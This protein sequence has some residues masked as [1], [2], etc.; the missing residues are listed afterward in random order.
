MTT[1][2]TN[3]GGA[4]I[5]A[6]CSSTF[7]SLKMEGVDYLGSLTATKT[8]D[9]CEAYAALYTG[10]AVGEKGKLCGDMVAARA[11]AQNQP[12]TAM[13]PGLVG[14]CGS[15]GAEALATAPALAEACAAA[16]ELENS[17]TVTVQQAGGAQSVA[18]LQPV[19]EKLP[20]GQALKNIA[21]RKAQEEMEAAGRTSDV[22]DEASTAAS[23]DSDDE[24]GGVVD[25]WLGGDDVA[26]ADGMMVNKVE[27][28]ESREDG[29]PEGNGDGVELEEVE[30]AEKRW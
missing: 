18:P 11:Q 17:E 29:L 1:A 4:N 15:F 14:Y 2:V 5:E 25:G 21:D 6:L 24:E 9:S 3:A 28:E 27:D 20:K 26:E 12:A 30:G 10:A 19:G 23:S 16:V 13:I 22:E 7:Q 8:L